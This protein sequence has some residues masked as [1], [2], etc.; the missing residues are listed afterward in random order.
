MNR[1]VFLFAFVFIISGMQGLFA[2]EA[3]TWHLAVV[4]DNQGLSFDEAVDMNTGESLSIDIYTEK[5]CYVYLVVEQAGGA[6]ATLFSRQVRA[7]GVERLF[8]GTLSPPRGQE[9]FYLVTSYEEQREL[10]NAINDYKKEKTERNGL[11]LQ[12]RLLAVRDPNGENPG[13]PGDFA[14]SV[15][16]GDETTRGTVYSGASTY[17]KTILINH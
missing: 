6:M 15:R 10:Q 14:G 13:G 8:S 4:K 7:G 2:Q 11:R 5:D 9:K 1:K 16:S 12:N 3:F 17:T